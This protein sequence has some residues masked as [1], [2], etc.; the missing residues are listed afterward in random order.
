VRATESSHLHLSEGPCPSYFSLSTL[1][2]YLVAALSAAASRIP[3]AVDA[4]GVSV[5]D[6]LRGN[7]ASGACQMTVDTAVGHHCECLFQ[8]NKEGNISVGGY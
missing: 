6:I 8:L 7:E 3:C 5:A 2:L 4:V 1:L